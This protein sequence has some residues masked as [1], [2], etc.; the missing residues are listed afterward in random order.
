MSLLMGREEGAGA[1]QLIPGDG[2]MEIVGVRAL[3][4]KERRGSR[5]EFLYIHIG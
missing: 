1:E 2:D 3:R 4:T 5:I